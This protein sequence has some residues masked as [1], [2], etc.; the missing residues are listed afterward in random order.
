MTLLK[1]TNTPLLDLLKRDDSDVF[2]G[3]NS[4]YL[5]IEIIVDLG[6]RHHVC[7]LAREELMLFF[8]VIGM[9][10]EVLPSSSNSNPR[11]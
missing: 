4:F 2:E 7:F 3:M 1:P 5:T 11:Y 6:K 9:D 8:F 10:K